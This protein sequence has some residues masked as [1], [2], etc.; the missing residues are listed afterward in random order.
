M[1]NI[2]T[3]TEFSE[4]ARELGIKS[5]SVEGLAAALEGKRDATVELL[6]ENNLSEPSNID[7]NKKTKTFTYDCP[8]SECGISHGVELAGALNSLEAARG[9]IANLPGSFLKASEDTNGCQ[10]VR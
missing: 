3:Q 9:M 5:L 4:R 1:T 7:F 10:W 8:I 6:V 2:D